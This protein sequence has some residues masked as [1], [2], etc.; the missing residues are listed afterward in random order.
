M[1]FEGNDIPQ[2]CY[3]KARK[4]ALGKPYSRPSIVQKSLLKNGVAGLFI[5]PESSLTSMPPRASRR[6]GTALYHTR[7]PEENFE[8][9]ALS[10]AECVGVSST[11]EYSRLKKRPSY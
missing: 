5:N 4:F 9:I 11:S 1:F 8:S 7:L 2:V 3:E 6:W 10:L